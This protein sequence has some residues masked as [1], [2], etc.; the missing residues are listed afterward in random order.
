[1]V[2]YLKYQFSGRRKRYENL[3]LGSLDTRQKCK[4]IIFPGTICNPHGLNSDFSIGVGDTLVR[5]GSNGG[6][7]SLTV[8]L[9]IFLHILY[10]K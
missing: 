2:L 10:E 9:S 5:E 8:C 3:F 1:M 7:I 4:V 6:G